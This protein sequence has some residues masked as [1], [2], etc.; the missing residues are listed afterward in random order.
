MDGMTSNLKAHGANSA[1]IFFNINTKPVDSAG[2]ASACVGDERT[3]HTI[4]LN[5]HNEEKDTDFLHWINT[6]EE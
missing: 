6:K 1:R 3:I 5:A 2:S 4:S